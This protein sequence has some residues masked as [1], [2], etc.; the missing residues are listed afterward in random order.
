MDIQIRQMAK[1]LGEA[2]LPF[3]FLC[4][5]HWDQ[6]LKKILCSLPPPPEQTLFPV[7][8]D[9]ILEGLSHPGK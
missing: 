1:L 6:L 9:S 4:T 2:A 5:S 8:D 7:R 3:S